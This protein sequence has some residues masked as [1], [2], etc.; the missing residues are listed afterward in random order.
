MVGTRKTRTP[1]LYRVKEISKRR[2]KHLAACSDT[3]RSVREHSKT[4][5][6]T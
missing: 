6:N 3:L 4:P 2:I 1:D 5:E